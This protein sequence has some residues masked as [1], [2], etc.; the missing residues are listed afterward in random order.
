MPWRGDEDKEH[1]IS[2]NQ[3]IVETRFKRTQHLLRA[4]AGTAEIDDIKTTT[5]SVSKLLRQG[6]PIIQPD[7]KVKESP[8]NPMTADVLD[9][10]TRRRKFSSIVFTTS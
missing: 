6:V 8:K 7:A 4:V 10:S 5:G 3:A 9:A 1:R 2:S